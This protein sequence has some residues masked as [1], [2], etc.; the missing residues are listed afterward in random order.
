MALNKYETAAPQPDPAHIVAVTDFSGAT[1]RSIIDHLE[2]ST[3][4]EH[5]V[6]RESELDAL[7]SI[8]GFA[9]KSEPHLPSR[10]SI[11]RLHD[12]AHR[13]HDLIAER[14]PREAAELLRSFL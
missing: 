2:V 12:I 14:R 7:W 4:F 6:Y 11:E 1:L 9:L 3:D 5:L 10:A 8:T 13:A